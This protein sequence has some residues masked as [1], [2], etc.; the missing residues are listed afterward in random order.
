MIK[1]FC[2]AFAVFFNLFLILVIGFL[3]V[4]RFSNN[5][6][7]EFFNV[8]SESMTPNIPIGSLV[9]T[10]DIDAKN[11]KKGDVVTYQINNQ[12]V[13]HRIVSISKKQNEY[14]FIT[15]GDA[16]NTADALPVSDSQ[17]VG[18]LMFHLPKLGRFG[19][20]IKTKK[21]LIALCSTTLQLMLLEEWIKLYKIYLAENRANKSK[22]QIGGEINEENV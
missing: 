20:I 3:L 1:K 11:L 8:L 7:F 19:E 10:K 14:E 16:N 18:K 15:K 6:P 21:G 22:I 5:K 13:T 4:L 9:I 17:I 2:K 12:L